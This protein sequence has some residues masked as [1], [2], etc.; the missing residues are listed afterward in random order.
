MIR[1]LAA[2]P[3]KAEGGTVT[4]NVTHPESPS[5]L[6]AFR[7]WALSRGVN[8]AVE[9][10]VDKIQSPDP[11]VPKAPVDFTLWQYEGTTPSPAVD[12]ADPPDGRRRRADRSEPLQPRALRD[13]EGP[14][15]PRAH[16]AP[17]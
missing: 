16:Q 17:A 6:N 9:L 13:E 1:Q 15:A 7:L 14:R 2:D 3:Q 5:V 10:Q 12:A 8:V 11:R 4:L